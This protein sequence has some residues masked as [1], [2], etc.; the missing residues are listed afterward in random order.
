MKTIMDS[1]KIVTAV[2]ASDFILGIF[3][4]QLGKTLAS[5]VLTAE[6]SEQATLENIAWGVPI[7]Q[8]TQT[9]PEYGR[10]GNLLMWETYKSLAGCYLLTLDG[11]KAAK[12]SPTDRTVYADGTTL[13]ETK[14]NVMHYSPRLYFRMATDTAGQPTLWMSLTPIPG[15]NYIEEQWT[16][17]YMGS[18]DSAGRLRSVSG[19]SV[20]NN[21]TITDFWTAAQKNSSEH[22]LTSYAHCR[23]WLMMALAESGNTNTQMKFGHGPTGQA[24]VFSKVSGLTTGATA[25]FGDACGTVDISEVSGNAYSCHVSFFGIENLWGWFW[26]MTQGLTFSGTTAIVYEGNRMPNAQELAGTPTGV[27]R[28]FT[29]LTQNG[30]VRK[31]IAGEHFDIL[32]SSVTGGDSTTG[33]CDSSWANDTGQLFLFGGA[34]YTG[35]YCG[36]AYVNSIHAFG[37]RDGHCGAR[38]AFYGKPRL[39]DGRAIA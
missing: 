21:K 9:N 6:G 10:V 31:I 32:P 38:L 5:N 39:V 34:A 37:G 25:S 27:D 24:D 19:A 3:G 14:G 13:D 23:K 26:H 36:L 15:G 30:Y 4:G 11:S 18:L 8:D 29:R 33:W 7:K 35:A 2:A 22:G 28:T 1:A 16:G 20:A 12:L 17:C